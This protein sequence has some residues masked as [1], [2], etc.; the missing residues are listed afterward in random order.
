[1][2]R[3]K[4]EKETGEMDWTGGNDFKGKSCGEKRKGG[5]GEGKDWGEEGRAG[6]G[7]DV[8]GEEGRSL[9]GRVSWLAG[10]SRN[11]PNHRPK[12]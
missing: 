12:S 9:G 1:M 2:G 7:K 5:G 11:T 3:K 6:E 10:W 8:T 4:E